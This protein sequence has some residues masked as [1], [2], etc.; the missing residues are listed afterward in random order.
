MELVS[1]FRFT[2][3]FPAWICWICLIVP[4]LV[5]M[6]DITLEGGQNAT[7]H[8]STASRVRRQAGGCNYN[9]QFNRVGERATLRSPGYP[10]SY[11]NNIDCRYTI[12]SPAGTRMTLDCTEFNLEPSQN[13]QY[14]VFF[15]SPSGDTSFRDQQHFCGAGGLLALVFKLIS[16]CRIYFKIIIHDQKLKVSPVKPPAID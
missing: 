15:F 4:H 9:F 14:D 1:S 11:G 10:N 7:N 13:C 16:D 8:S 5:V 3:S 2:T 12:S 6:A